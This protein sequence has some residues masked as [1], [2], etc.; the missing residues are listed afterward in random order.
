M[1]LLFLVAAALGVSVLPLAALGVSV[2]PLAALG[3]SVLLPAARAER[4][5]AQKLVAGPVVRWQSAPDL[6]IP[7]WRRKR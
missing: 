6:T 7:W 5:Q 4:R 1:K 2:L 3:V